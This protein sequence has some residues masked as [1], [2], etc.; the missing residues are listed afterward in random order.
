MNSLKIIVVIAIIALVGAA[1]GINIYKIYNP[2]EIPYSGVTVGNEYVSTSTAS[3]V[4]ADTVLTSRVSTLGSVIV[5]GVSSG[6]WAIW[7]AT[8]T[9]DTASTTLT[10]F[11]T[12]SIN[13]TYTFDAVMDRGISLQL[14][15][16]YDGNAVITYRY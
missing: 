10:T 13:G 8:S 15:A 2:V 4:I 16:G 7:N 14:G 1:L 11:D 9:T 6:N 3:M 12:T 5:T